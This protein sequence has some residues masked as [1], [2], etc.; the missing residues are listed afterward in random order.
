MPFFNSPTSQTSQ[1][2]F[3][4]NTSNDAVLHK[5]VSF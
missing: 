4:L 2:I 1:G 5:E 3:M